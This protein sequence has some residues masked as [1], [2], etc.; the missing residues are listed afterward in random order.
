MN[1]NPRK[2]LKLKKKTVHFK[3][4]NTPVVPSSALKKPSF[5]DLKENDFALKDNAVL[6]PKERLIAFVRETTEENPDHIFFLSAMNL[7]QSK[8]YI[9]CMRTELSRFRAII[10]HEK[11][12]K[13]VPFK[14]YTKEISLT[15]KGCKI[16]LSRGK[17]AEI[18]DEAQ[19]ALNILSGD[20]K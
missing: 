3:P 7:K 16:V 9:Q 5:I 12:R 19:E 14:M 4:D 2:I 20:F 15:E 18:S 11:K 8:N 1:D 10:I 17:V 6:P 13:P